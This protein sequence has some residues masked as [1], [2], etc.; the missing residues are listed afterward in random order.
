[1]IKIHN[2]SKEAFNICDKI[3]P[4]GWY[5]KDYLIEEADTYNIS[6]SP[7][8]QITKPA[9]EDKIYLTYNPELKTAV[10][11]FSDFSTVTII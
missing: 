8:V 1:M 7:T 5:A 3:L 4:E 11:D 6:L 10:L 2:L 9:E